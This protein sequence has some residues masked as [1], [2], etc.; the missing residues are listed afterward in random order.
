M[1]RERG[2]AV[3]T[4]LA[5]PP[6]A[7]RKSE[8]KS[9]TSRTTDT[10]Q[11]QEVVC[12]NA[13]GRAKMSGHVRGWVVCGEDAGSPRSDAKAG[14]APFSGALGWG[15]GKGFCGRSLARRPILPLR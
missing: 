4:G 11:E 2:E 7:D 3:K 10:A 1:A 13:D 15:S 5:D 6:L 12:R 14:W 8:K 9:P